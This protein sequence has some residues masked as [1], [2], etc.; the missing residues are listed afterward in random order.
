MYVCVCVC[1]QLSYITAL[2][3]NESVGGWGRGGRV[4]QGESCVRG[5]MN[6]P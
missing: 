2:C 1:V 6:E 3:M 4:L 5:R